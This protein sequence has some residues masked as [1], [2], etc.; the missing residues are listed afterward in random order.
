MSA[1][2]SDGDV[3]VN[4]ILCADALAALR[5][6][7]NA[8]VSLIV[9]SPPYWDTIDYGVA[10]QLG[11]TSYERYVADLLDVWR[12]AERVLVPNGKLC[13]NTPIL[14]VPKRVD[15]SAHTRQLKNINNDLECSML[16]GWTCD[17]VARPP[18]GLLRYSLFVWQKQT[19]VKMFGSYPCPPNLYEDNTIEFINVF[20]KPG[21]PRRLPT[22]VKDASRLTQTQW[23]NLTMQVWPLYPA[24]VSRTGGHPAPFPPALPGRLI[25]MYT[26][27][28]VPEAGFDGDIV[29]DMFNGTGATCVAAASLGRRY[30]GIDLNPDY[31][32]IARE[33]VAG[34][35]LDPADLLLERVRLGRKDRR[36]RGEVAATAARRPRREDGHGAKD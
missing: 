5:R 34:E 11:R 2:S 12:E 16:Y 33:R 15:G 30:V 13:I 1:R 36:S 6:L 3:P 32:R 18:C 10:G 7:P 35:T 27:R 29:L 19:T 4:T 25:A 8:C 22:A 20:V 26:F 14:P 28:A 9:T 24:N 21:A 23:L 31:C 17:G